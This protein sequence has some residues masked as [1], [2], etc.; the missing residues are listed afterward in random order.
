VELLLE[1]VHSSVVDRRDRVVAV[2][3]SMVDDR[4]FVVV[5]EDKCPKEPDIDYCNPSR[6][7]VLVDATRLV[8]M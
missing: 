8:R 4:T 7:N 3:A 6:T 2:R 1:G 5:V